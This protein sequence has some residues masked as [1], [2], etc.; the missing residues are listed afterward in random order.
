MPPTRMHDHELTSQRLYGYSFFCCITYLE[1]PHTSCTFFFRFFCYPPPTFFRVAS[2][3]GHLVFCCIFLVFVFFL[4]CARLIPLY[5]AL[6]SQLPSLVF[7]V[8]YA[9]LDDF[10]YSPHPPSYL[11]PPFTR[12]DLDTLERP[13]RLTL[14][15]L[16]TF[17][18]YLS[19]HSHNFPCLL[20][21]S[22]EVFCNEKYLI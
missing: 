9:L 7:H 8:K 15:F 20:N 11:S 3:S 4:S 22:S 1:T 21:P 12:P 5:P 10:L 14:A 18:L 16:D 2:P 17:P 6:P 13:I 19:Y